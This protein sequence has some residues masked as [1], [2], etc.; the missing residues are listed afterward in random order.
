MLGRFRL[1]IMLVGF[2]VLSSVVVADEPAKEGEA[3]AAEKATVP[4]AVRLAMQD[5]RYD[6]AVMAIDAAPAGSDAQAELLMYLKGRALFLAK[7]YD[8]AINAYDAVANK[9]PDGQWGRRARFAKGVAYARGGEFRKAELVYR[10]EAEALL[11][12]DRK[13]EIADI[14]LEFADAYFEPPEDKKP[15]YGKALQFYAKALEVGPKPE[16]REKTELL[17]AQCQQKLGQ[18]DQAASLYQKFLKDHKNSDL[19]IE[20]R[21][22]LGE[23]QLAG[24]NRVEAR[25]TWQDLLA[26]HKGSKSP[27]MAEAAYNLS[28]TYAL[29]S[30]DDDEQLALGVA[31]LRAF[32]KKYPEHESADKA[33][34][35]IARSYM[36]RNRYE[37]AVKA[38]SDYLEAAGESSAEQIPEA[39]KMLGLAYRAQSD[40]DN[41]LLSWRDFLGKHPTHKDWSQVQGWVIEVEFFKAE[42]A[43]DRE[44]YDDARKLYNEFLVKYP[45]DSRNR[46]IL[47]NFGQMDYAREKWEA[48]ITQ[49]RRLVSKYPKCNEASQA[50]YLIA[51]TMETKLG[52]LEESIEE[53]KK[54]NWGSHESSAKQRLAQ[55]TAKTMTIATERVFRGDETPQLKLTSRN[56]ENVTVQLYVVDLETYFRKMH[57]ARGVEGLDIALID[58]DHTFEFEVPKYEK[59]RELESSIPLLIPPIKNDKGQPA[60]VMA[61]TVSSKT[62]EATTLVIAS[63]LDI[64]VKSSRDE[65]FVFAQ[66]MV[67]GKPWADATILLSNGEDVFTEAKTDE[68]GILHQSFDELES[69]DGVRVFALSGDHVASNLVNLSGLSVAE[70]LTDRGYI[71]TDRPAYRAGQVVHVRGII[72]QA[73]D[74]VYKVTPNDEFLV[75]VF[76]NRNRLV[77][78]ADVELNEFGSFH[79]TILLPKTAPQGTYRI[80]VTD[81]EEKQS[82]QG[83]FVVHEYRLEPVRLEIEAERTVFYRGELIEGTIKASYYY[84]APVVDREIRYQLADG[85]SYTEKTDKNGEVSFSLPTRDF[86]ES[87][88]LLLSVSLPERNLQTGKSFFLATQG[89]AISASTARPLYLAG[90]TFELKVSASSPEGKP[91]AK[92]LTLSVLKKTVIDG[93]TGEKP[94]SEHELKTDEETGIARQTL[95]LDEGGKYVLRLEGTDRFGNPIWGS[96][97]VNVSDDDDR[98]RLRILADKHTFKS[99]DATDIRLHWREEPALALVTYQGAKIL[100]HQ[101][102]SLQK[103]LNKLPVT[104]AAKLAPNFD[105][106]ISVMTDPRDRKDKDDNPARR[107]HNA[108]SSFFVQRELNVALKIVKKGDA[109][110]Q[111]QPGDEVEVT[112]TTTDPQGRPVAAEIGLALVEQALLQQFSSPVD[113]IQDFFRGRQRKSAV[114][115][116]SS[117]TFAYRPQTRAI[118]TRLLAE[119]DRVAL[120]EEEGRR[121]AALRDGDFGNLATGSRM[122]VGGS[123]MAEFNSETEGEFLGGIE[124]QQQVMQ[125]PALSQMQGGFGYAQSGGQQSGA[126]FGRRFEA[127]PSNRPGDSGHFRGA[128]QSVD[129]SSIPFADRSLGFSLLGAQTMQHL[130]RHPDGVNFD[131]TNITLNADI[132]PM[133][134]KQV[135]TYFNELAQ[136]NS[137]D[138]VVVNGSAW[139]NFNITHA[140]GVNAEQGE[141]EK[142]VDKLQKRGAT[143]LPNMR[144][145]ETGYWNPAIVTDEDGKASVTFTLPDRS[146]A[147]QLLATGATVETLTGEATD[148]LAVRKDLFGQLKTPTSLTDGDRATII[149][150]VHNDRLDEGA[151][152]VTLKT[153]IGK[154][155]T[156]ETKTLDVTGKGIEELRFPV[157]IGLPAGESSTTAT[158]DLSIAVAD[159]PADTVKRVVPVKPYGRPVFAIAGGTAESDT[160]AFIDP[161]AGMTLTAPQLQVLLGPTV[162]QSLLDALFATPTL[163]QFEANATTTWGDTTVGDLMAALALQKLM[164]DSRE[165][166]NPQLE[167]VDARVR[168][169]IRSL[170]SIQNDDGGWSWTGR[171]GASNRFSTAR[172][173]WAL[174]LAKKGGY[175]I[176]DNAISAGKNFLR[177]QLAAAAVTD[178]DT[179]AILLHAMTV[180]GNGD[181]PLANQLYRNRQTLSTTALAHLTLALAEM[182]RM[183]TAGELLTILSER[184]FEETAPK[185]RSSS[186]SLPWCHSETELRA[187]YALALRKVAPSSPKLEQQVDW[188]IGH[189]TGHRWSPEKATGPAM[190]ALC[191]W[192]GQAT[193][194]GE[195]YKLTVFVNDLLLKEIEVDDAATTIPLDVPAELLS[196]KSRQTVRFEITGRGRYS[197]QCV[198]SGFVPADKLKS[199]TEDW[200]VERFYEPAPLELDGKPIRRGFD[201]LTGSYDTFRNDMTQLPV[202]K[203]GHVELRVYRRN[204]PHTTPD[205]HID[206]LVVTE[207]L[208]AGATVVRQSIRGPFDRYEITPGAITFFIGSRRHAGSIHFDVHGYLPGDYRAGPTLV[209]DA[210]AIDQ[211]AVAPAKSLS[212]LPFGE[213]SQDAYKL[214]PRE[215]YDLGQRLYEKKDL[216]GAAEHL[217]KLFAMPNLAPQYYKESARMLFDAHLETGPPSEIVRYLEVV[218]EKYPEMEIPFAKLVKVGDAYHQIGEYER[219]YLVYRAICEGSFLRESQVAGFLQGQGEFLRSVDVMSNLLKQYPPES[220]VAAATYALAQRV[221]AKAPEAA[222]DPKLKEKKITRVDVI[223]RALGMLDEF[224]TAYPDDPAADEASF[225]LASGLL[226]MDAYEKAIAACD[227][228]Q[229]RYPDSEYLDSYWYI[230]GYSQFALGKHEDALAMCE[231][232]AEAKRKNPQSGREEESP[233]K[234]RAI[235][236]LGQ[237]HH[238]LGKAEA[239]IREYTRVEDRFADARQAIAYFSRKDIKL[240]EVATVKPGEEIEVELA[241]RNVAACDVKVYRIDLMKFSLLK[242]NLGGIT[243]INLAGIRPYH[244]TELELGDGKDYRDRTANL[245]LPL[246]DLGA[247]LVVCRGENLHTSGLVL[248]SP[249][250]VE[251]QEDS[252]SGRVRTTVR[253]ATDDSYVSEV[254]V[255]VIGSGNSDFESGETDLRGIYVADGIRGKTTVIAQLDR[256]QYAFFRGETHLGPQPQPGSGQSDPFG[257]GHAAPAEENMQMDS[258]SQLLEGLKGGNYKIQ[259]EQQENL[260]ELYNNPNQGG[261]GGGGMF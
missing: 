148:E 114:R 165:A 87:Q 167:A 234:W 10:A 69:A 171:G 215:L 221:Y 88:T 186:S 82:Y 23:S 90:E 68:N 260:Q 181:F 54:V 75:E 79:Q 251:I 121:I 134:R 37:D 137:G 36:H 223:R 45:L 239:A 91:V 163:C 117:V 15:N 44:K 151:I 191:G 50:Q 194:T 34:L 109:E 154:K 70:G 127:Q 73:V 52:K 231:K 224:L 56:L 94:V 248:V 164:A 217:T 205:D 76:D 99:G 113:I 71:Y 86:R 83:S 100:D 40:F 158:F 33:H 131:G 92:N 170:I 149:A 107:F 126:R 141:V 252:Q 153:T 11:S 201:V 245:K 51:N 250:T 24:G 146:T 227:S 105:L 31:S 261:F 14:Y 3:L 43:F 255:K 139:G 112:V 1:S 111:P 95:K 61:V 176:S 144:P 143:L 101:L 35:R 204:L 206:Y 249:L 185:W 147:W 200:R 39:R 102:I 93:Q 132:S 60:G 222:D 84:G 187:L 212:V 228:Y 81:N 233:N 193:F 208:P 155:S 72:R 140:L 19:V 242:R 128:M 179:R 175:R 18:H 66:N 229:K 257:D 218:I 63:D 237:I 247:Y 159:R 103:G 85:R 236:I 28:S 156:T 160:T 246:K 48:A 53:Y 124:D 8:E 106:D 108:R 21:Y 22:R 203:K 65:V 199:T 216:K 78:H 64:I 97:T 46:R 29:P 47:Y 118:N 157:A 104:M 230:V 57:L 207:P 197:Y 184:N 189:R 183:Q 152:E 58:P 202:G 232:V 166:D 13:Q 138:M 27:R 235:Y 38:L 115:T 25:R 55:L 129:E 214:S 20:A 172:S 174:S 192:Y 59:H 142:L 4:A 168:S 125:G 26:L 182:D 178:Y 243:N 136:S 173:M 256:N 80:A 198:L 16:S 253:D 240:P 213:K 77:Q 238:S 30:P 12:L 196:K 195:K 67:T 259:Q 123:L 120:A 210:Y 225:S 180:A 145:Q 89:F 161:P 96:T 188:L 42:D 254:H 241:F 119:A 209:R 98:T 130:K 110:A 5:R 150:S 122:S 211:I 17:I 258:K 116:V 177:S 32:L 220:Y 169:S 133:Y 244:E 162:E 190:L 41:A 7:K 62:M 2:V 135:A 74:D 226:E 6:D 9:F 49:W 219:S